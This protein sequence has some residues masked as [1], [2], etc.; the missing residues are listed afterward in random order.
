MEEMTNLTNEVTV[1]DE[2]KGLSK[3]AVAGIAG[4]TGAAIGGLVGWLIRGFFFKK[5]L[6]EL[7]DEAVDERMDD[8]DFV[9]YEETT[10][11]EPETKDADK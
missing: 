2:K 4:G 7:V 5:H 11:T 1:V 6:K 3:K 8:D 9:E 10:E